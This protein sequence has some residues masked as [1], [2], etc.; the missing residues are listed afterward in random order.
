MYETT[1]FQ[2]RVLKGFPKIISVL[3]KVEKGSNAVNEEVD[4][5][6]LEQAVGLLQ[7]VKKARRK[8]IIL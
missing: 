7:E 8:M 2:T 4:I 3:T 1:D 5:V 6:K